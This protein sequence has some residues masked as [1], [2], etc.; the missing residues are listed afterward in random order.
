[1]IEMK[2]SIKTFNSIIDHSGERISKLKYR[3]Y[4]IIQLEE[5]KEERTTKSKKHSND[6]WNKW[7][8]THIIEVPE[9]AET[10]SRKIIL[11]NNDWKLPKSGEGN[12]YPDSWCPKTL[13][14]AEHQKSKPRHIIFK[15][16]EV[17][18]KENFEISKRKMTH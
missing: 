7:I 4:E 14:E 1:M 15:F 6:W 13:Q 11:K 5:Q 17:K 12:V 18:D 9:E 3:A 2:N 8:N 10:K 16:S